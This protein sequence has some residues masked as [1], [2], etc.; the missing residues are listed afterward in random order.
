M[1]DHDQPPEKASELPPDVLAAMKRM[2]GSA[3]SKY[4]GTLIPLVK[5]RTVSG[6]VAGNSGFMLSLDDGSWVVAYLL[7]AKMRWAR[8]TGA[9]EDRTMRLVSSPACGSGKEPLETDVP[10]ADQICELKA[11]L[12]KAHGKTITG[13]AIGETEFNFC[14]PEGRELDAMIVKDSSGKDALR[15]FWEQW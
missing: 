3:Y 9:P 8:G 5:G 12:R 7:D 13:L 4:V 11:E 10:Y 6:S 1:L 2:Q 15:V 14:F